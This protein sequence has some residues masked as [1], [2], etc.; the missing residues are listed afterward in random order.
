MTVRALSSFRSAL[1]SIVLSWDLFLSTSCWPLFLFLKIEIEANHFGGIYRYFETDPPVQRL[2]SL[3]GPWKTPL[4]HPR[5]R[6][7]LR[8]FTAKVPVLRLHCG[9]RSERTVVVDVSVGG[10]LLRG[11]CDRGVYAVLQTLNRRSMEGRK[12]PGEWR[13]SVFSEILEGVERLDRVSDD[14]PVSSFKKL[15]VSSPRGLLFVLFGLRRDRR[16]T[17]AALCRL[18]KLWAKRR[19]L[20]NTLRGGLSSFS[21]VLLTVFFLQRKCALPPAPQVARSELGGWSGW[22]PVFFV[23]VGRLGHQ[24]VLLPLVIKFRASRMNL[25]PPESYQ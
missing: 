7:A 17:G 3:P 12:I 9:A 15:K 25:E 23:V 22:L 13:A 4:R 5:I 2:S 20:T 10:S 1:R 11:A 19:K 21:F 18:V 6:V 14:L 16:R 24:E 8:I